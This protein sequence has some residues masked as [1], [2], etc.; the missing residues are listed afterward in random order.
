MNT[1]QKFGCR[2]KISIFCRNSWVLKVIAHEMSDKI[3]KKVEFPNFMEFLREV[4]I[5][6]SKDEY[7]A[8]VWVLME[9]FN[10]LLK[11]LGFKGYSPRNEWQ[12]IKKIKIPIFHGMI[13]G[14]FDY[15]FLG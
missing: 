11:F 12:N 15:N 4:L 1:V 5:I 10:F 9:I 7:Y 13:K 6:I 8:Q 14:G 2:W 3:Q